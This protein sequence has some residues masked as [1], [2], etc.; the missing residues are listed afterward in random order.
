MFLTFLSSELHSQLSKIDLYKKRYEI[1]T[2]SMLP[3]E[4]EEHH[5]EAYY[6]IKAAQEREE[7]TRKGDELDAKIKKAESEIA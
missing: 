1:V 2:M 5:S 6:V 4:G 3:P 7:L